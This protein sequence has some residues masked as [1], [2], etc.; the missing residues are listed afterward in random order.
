MLRPQF[1]LS[2]IFVKL[3]HTYTNI[4]K[5]SRLINLHQLVFLAAEAEGFGV[6]K[7]MKAV[8][9]I[10]ALLQRLG[11][12]TSRI[13]VTEN[14]VYASLDLM[15]SLLGCLNNL[16]STCSGTAGDGQ[17]RQQRSER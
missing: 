7:D 17:N 3:T 8:L 12:I 14:K 2:D 11:I 1:T 13:S 6:V 9:T 16:R 10:D 15:G 5:N 4:A